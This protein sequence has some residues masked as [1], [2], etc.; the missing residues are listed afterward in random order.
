M[1]P[2]ATATARHTPAPEP[3]GR[4]SSRITRSGRSTRTSWVAS[5]ADPGSPTMLKPSGSN[6]WRQP[7]LTSSW[8]SSKYMRCPDVEGADCSS[9]SAMK[10][11]SLLHHRDLTVPI[12]SLTRVPRCDYEPPSPRPA[13]PASTQART[14][15]HSHARPIRLAKIPAKSPSVRDHPRYPSGTA[16]N[17]DGGAT[18]Q[19]R[20]HPPLSAPRNLL[21]GL[22]GG[23]RWRSVPGVQAPGPASPVL[24]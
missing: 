9:R 23:P 6:N 22:I 3:S 8:S 12:G 7:R 24:V 1:D 16:I 15:L 14:N 11:R 17:D 4:S 13:L 19:I 20:P 2:F 21:P 5:R 18:F 10:S